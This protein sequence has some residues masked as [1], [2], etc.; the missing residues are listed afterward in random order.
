[1]QVYPIAIENASLQ[2][3]VMA[4]RGLAQLCALNPAYINRISDVLGQLLMLGMGKKGGEGILLIKC[5][6]FRS[7]FG[8]FQPWYTHVRLG[9]P[10]EV[11]VVKQVFKAVMEQDSAAVLTSLLQ[12]VGAM[13]HEIS[14]IIT[15][16]KRQHLVVAHL[17]I[18]LFPLWRL[19]YINTKFTKPLYTIKII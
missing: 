11:Q 12:L 5:F 7:G 9:S 2:I 3:R 16:Q 14:R 15:N 19:A 18:L 4:I 6:I 8:W 13:F 1:M 17:L 10:H